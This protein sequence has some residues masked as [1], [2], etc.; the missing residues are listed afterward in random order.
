MEYVIG[1]DEAGRG[2]LAGPVAVGAVLL[3]AHLLWEDFDG[4]KDS[5]KL[6]AQQREEWFGKISARS[7]L[8]GLGDVSASVSLVSARTIDRD[9]IVAACRLA[10]RRCLTKIV[11]D[12]ANIPIWEL[13]SQMGVLLDKGLS[14]P[15]EWQQEQI[16]KGDETVPA[17]ALASIV[18]KVTRDRH[19]EHLAE[20]Y[21][22]YGFEG[23]KG[24]GTHEHRKA[25]KKHGLSEEHRTTFCT[26][27]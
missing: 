24:Y 25:I 18:A 2:A 5:K 15:S 1:V 14:A 19:M 23:H 7:P 17:I 4:L 20:K 21:K 6:R 12:T 9:G 11:A 22:P 3:P 8:A 10:T 27:L 26:R 16:V 13:S